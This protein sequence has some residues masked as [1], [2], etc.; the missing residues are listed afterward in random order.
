M[1]KRALRLLAVCLTL[2]L[3]CSTAAAQSA[4]D[5]EYT[6]AEKLL[7]QLQAGSGFTGTLTVESTAV[8]GREADAVTTT[9]PIT[10]GVDYIYVRPDTVAQS[11]GESRLSLA[12]TDGDTAQGKTE[13]ALRGG[14]LYLQSALFGDAWYAL[15]AGA[16]NP[17]AQSGK[18]AGAIAQEA[19]SLLQQSAMP[20]LT[21]F[22]LGLLTRLYDVDLTQWGEVLDPYATKVDVWIEGFRQSALLDKAADGTTTMRIDY[23]IPVTAVKAQIKQMV[24]DL[25]ADTALLEKLRALLPEADTQRYLDPTLQSYYFYAIDELPLNGDLTLSRTVSLKG[26]TRAL[27]LQLPLYDSQ[28]KAL[29]LRYDRQKGAGDLPDENTLELQSDKIVWKVV[30]QTYQSLTGTTV[31]QGT[32]LRTPIGEDAFAV[33]AAE[34]AQ[35]AA[36]KTIS[37]AFT[38]SAQ[39]AQGKDAEGKDTLTDTWAFSLTPDYTPDVA[40]DEAAEPTE[41]QQEQYITFD[42][43]DIQMQ[44]VFT[45]GQAKNAST[46]LDVTLSIAGDRSPQT[47]TLKLTGKTRGKWEPAALDVSAAQSLDTM[48]TAA[49]TQWIAQAGVKGGLLLLPYVS[50]PSQ[51]AA[52]AQPDATAQPEATAQPGA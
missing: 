36:Q 9:R 33:G 47:I 52:T 2:A 35:L 38:L 27:T 29:T 50:L 23:Q 31:Y 16:V 46:A 30:Y 41:A 13:L 43:L 6:V 15:S 3:L 37:A 19:S 12:V 34:P 20:G 32:L 44:T 48:D 7:K 40:D 14:K 8:A 49:L 22:A 28:G 51:S 1:K 39:Q 11:E 21:T 24:L 10:I 4:L 5:V 18:T 26:E 17:E 42:P 25:L 45:S